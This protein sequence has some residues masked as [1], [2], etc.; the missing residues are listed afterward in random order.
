VKEGIQP[1]TNNNTG[2]GVAFFSNLYRYKNIFGQ[3]VMGCNLRHL[4]TGD[5]AKEK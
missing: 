1:P 4:K 3:I 5:G 2:I